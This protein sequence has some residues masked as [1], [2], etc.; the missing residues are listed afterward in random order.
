MTEKKVGSVTHYYNNLHVA[1]VKITDGELHVGDMIHIDGNTSDFTVKIKS[2][3][4][5]HE[6]IEVAHAGDIV[7]IKID[8]NARKND[9]VYIA[10]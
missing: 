8:E 1:T 6:P 9:T 5:D 2:M 4:L 10:Y 7:G 3:E